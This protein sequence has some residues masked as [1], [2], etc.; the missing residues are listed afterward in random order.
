MQTHRCLQSPLP[1]TNVARENYR[2]LQRSDTRRQGLV[3]GRTKRQIS[4]GEPPW[5]PD[6]QMQDCLFADVQTSQ[7]TQQGKF[8]KRQPV[9][10]LA[11]SQHRPRV[12]ERHRGLK[13]EDSVGFGQHRPCGSKLE[14]EL[15]KSASC[16]A[17]CGSTV[18]LSGPKTT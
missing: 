16:T 1:E 2:I 17:L 14:P 4:T 12:G 3:A 5:C 7:V 13:C 6:P 11:G 9:G 15:E 8:T 18:G 10:F